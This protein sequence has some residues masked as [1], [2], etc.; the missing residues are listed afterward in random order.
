MIAFAGMAQTSDNRFAIPVGFGLNHLDAEGTREIFDLGEGSFGF[1][2]G[3]KYYL[4]PSFNLAGNVSRF[5]LDAEGF[6]TTSTDLDFGLEYKLANGKLLSEDSKFKPYLT[7]GIG[8]YF[9]DED[10]AIIIGLLMNSIF[11]VNRH[12][13]PS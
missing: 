2:T 3:L 7:G 9:D 13:K 6:S 4:S 5:K 11:L 8:G 10:F 12:Q 1:E